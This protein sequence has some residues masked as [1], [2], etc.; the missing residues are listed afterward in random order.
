[1]VQMG[2]GLTIDD[3]FFLAEKAYGSKDSKVVF[4]IIGDRKR[5][6]ESVGTKE[7]FEAVTNDLNSDISLNLYLLTISKTFLDRFY[8]KDDSTVFYVAGMLSRFLRSG[9]ADSVRTQML[10]ALLSGIEFPRQ[11]LWNIPGV[12]YQ[13]AGDIALF[14]SGVFEDNVR[15]RHQIKKKPLTIEDYEK[16]GSYSYGRAFK[17]SSTCQLALEKLSD[18]AYFAEARKALSEASRKHF[19]FDDY[20]AR[21]MK[22]MMSD[23]HERAARKSENL[24]VPYSDF[25]RFDPNLASPKTNRFR[26]LLAYTKKYLG[27]SVQ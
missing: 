10:D 2:A 8:I 23:A 12:S 5:L 21:L 25:R 27:F 22:R 3:Y 19:K 7:V 6:L 16:I 15:Y 24:S 20:F 9:D 26:M 18:K 14:N 11:Q 13:E 17:K 4:D 1:M